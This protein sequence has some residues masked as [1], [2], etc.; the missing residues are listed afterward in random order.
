MC[1][2]HVKAA[3]PQESPRF[4]HSGQENTLGSS[5]GTVLLMTNS[6]FD[7]LGGQRI[8]LDG[9]QHNNPQAPLI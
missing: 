6:G 9:A 5:L 8:A 1:M 2:R 7:Y 4:P 3:F